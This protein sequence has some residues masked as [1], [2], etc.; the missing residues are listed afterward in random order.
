[1]GDDFMLK[2]LGKR[3]LFTM[4]LTMLICV[5]AVP[6][7]T[8]ASIITGCTSNCH[9]NNAAFLNS[10]WF[11]SIQTAANITTYVNQLAANKIKL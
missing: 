5:G 1:M 10:A 11:S 2:K 8:S 6:T 7:L 3:F 4:I 9:V